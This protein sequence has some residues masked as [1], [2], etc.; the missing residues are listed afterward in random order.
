MPFNKL[1]VP[2]H[3]SIETCHAINDLLHDS[4][5]ETCGVNPEDYFCLV[6]RYSTEDMILHP[7]FLGNRDPASTVVIEIALLAGRS[8]EQKEALF[9]DVRRRLRGIDFNPENSIIFLIEN[10]P[11][12]WSFSEAGSVQSV[13]DP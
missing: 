2:R 7:T 1:H 10:R 11:I 3:L 4:L 13:F 9:K 8:D 6:S 12:D 5:V